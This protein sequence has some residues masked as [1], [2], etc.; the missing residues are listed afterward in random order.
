MNGGKDCPGSG[1]QTRACADW[2]CPG[3]SDHYFAQRVRL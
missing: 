2:S 1:N 3:M